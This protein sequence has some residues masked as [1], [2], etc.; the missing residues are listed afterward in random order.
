[1]RPH[2]VSGQGSL[3]FITCLLLPFIQNFRSTCGIGTLNVMGKYEA[4]DLHTFKQY[5][6][7]DEYHTYHFHNLFQAKTAV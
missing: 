7:I 1:M 2:I 6:F 4:D 3:G 5:N